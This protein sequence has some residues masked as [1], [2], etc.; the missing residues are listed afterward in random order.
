MG[1]NEKKSGQPGREMESGGNGV[2]NMRAKKE[3]Q[4]LKNEEN[5]T[6]MK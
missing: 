5:M 2:E 3:N 1:E 6:K 4:F